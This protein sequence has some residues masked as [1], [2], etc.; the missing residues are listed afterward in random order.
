MSFTLQAQT[1][2]HPVIYLVSTYRSLST[3]FLKMMHY[4]EDF[5]VINE[6]IF[7]LSFKKRFPDSDM[8][9]DY[10]YTRLDQIPYE[11][12]KFQ[13]QSPVFVKDVVAHF[14][15]ILNEIPQSLFTESNFHWVL[16][17]RD[18]ADI[19]LSFYKVMKGN[20]SLFDLYRDPQIFAARVGIKELYHIFERFRF[21]CK[22]SP[23]IIFT[24]QLASNP[25]STL[26]AFCHL[27][28]IP[29]SEN[30]LTWKSG[31]SDYLNISLPEN[32]E[33]P[34]WVKLF[35]SNTIESTH[36]GKMGSCHRDEFGEPTF[37]EVEEPDLKA[38]FHR[39]YKQ[40]IIYY[41]KLL[42]AKE[43]HLVQE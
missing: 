19:I 21:Q 2:E 7:D 23:K 29:F 4:R 36:F 11:L 20:T 28:Q 1:K 16:L 37:K 24:H 26:Q 40:N 43:F 13:K 15:D 32:G 39:V 8:Y 41:K 30:Q 10:V 5:K 38:L 3:S 25:K 9:R 6:P 22:N 18:P 42:E 27:Y 34:D 12:K 17:V 31:E 33:R 35:F 14:H